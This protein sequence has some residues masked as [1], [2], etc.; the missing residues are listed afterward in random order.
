M[1][2]IEE[3]HSRQL[4]L[5]VLDGAGFTKVARGAGLKREYVE[6]SL[7]RLARS[8]QTVVG[9]LEVEEWANP[10]LALLHR[11]RANYL[12]ALEHY[13]PARG[14]DPVARVRSPAPVMSIG[15][16]PASQEEASIRP[17]TG[18]W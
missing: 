11:H 12:E 13:H 8:L 3:T 2:H 5:E 10:T 6:R 18:H 9:V 16:W 4:L 15:F 14:D 1:R 17:G 7:R